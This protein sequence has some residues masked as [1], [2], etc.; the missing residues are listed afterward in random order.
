MLP[1]GIFM[2]KLSYLIIIWSSC[3]KELKGT[4]QV[5]QNKAAR[6]VTRNDRNAHNAENH[7]QLGWLSVNQL[8]FYHKVLQLQKL[9]ESK[10]PANLYKMFDWN[11]TYNTRQSCSGMIKPN[12]TPRLQTSK[13]TFRWSSA[14]CFNSLPVELR[15]LKD[16]SRFKHEVHSWIQ[17]TVPFK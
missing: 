16:T 3:S 9:R 7:K 12:G 13:L 6:A 1:N 10:L 14:E 11:Y 8:S 2:S 5:L 15:L 17:D 4:L